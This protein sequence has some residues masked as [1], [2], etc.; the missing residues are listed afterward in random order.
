[1]MCPVCVFSVSSVLNRT[2]PESTDDNVA[3][4]VEQVCSEHL[5]SRLVMRDDDYKMRIVDGNDERSDLRKRWQTHAMVE[6]CSELV[7][8]LDDEVVAVSRRDGEIL[9]ADVAFTSAKKPGRARRLTKWSF[10]NFAF[11][12]Q[13]R[14]VAA[15]LISVGG[16]LLKELLVPSQGIVG[17]MT[18]VSQC[19]T[20]GWSAAD[21]AGRARAF[22]K[23]DRGPTCTE[24]TQHVDKHGHCASSGNDEIW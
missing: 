9:V 23:T 20:F 14:G 6:V 21:R 2:T 1:M 19:A 10:R 7:A 15:K 12:P 17:A 24:V 22:R 11:A 16:I 18:P 13:C 4:M 5:F 3:D 8:P